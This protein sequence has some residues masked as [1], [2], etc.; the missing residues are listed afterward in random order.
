[1]VKKYYCLVKVT[2]YSHDGYRIGEEDI[3]IVY[4]KKYSQIKSLRDLDYEEN[5]ICKKKSSEDEDVYCSG[6]QKYTVIKVLDIFYDNVHNECVKKEEK[7]EPTDE[8]ELIKFYKNLKDKY[9]ILH[10]FLSNDC[11]CEN[12]KNYIK[13]RWCWC[14]NCKKE[15]ISIININGKNRLKKD[16]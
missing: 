2:E 10:N 9:N 16:D 3:S 13:N 5:C 1:M 11:Q 15:N 7:E 4:I 14:K 12:C 6:N 8:D